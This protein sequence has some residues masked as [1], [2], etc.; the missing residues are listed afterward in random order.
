[1]M[2]ARR[3]PDKNQDN[4]EK[5]EECF[6]KASQTAQNMPHASHRRQH[7]TTDNKERL[8]SA[9]RTRANTH[10]RCPGAKR[11]TYNIHACTTRTQ[12]AR[13][14][15]ATQVSEAYDVLHNPEKRK[16]YDQFG[17]QGLGGG[18]GCG[19]GG[20]SGFTSAQA[21]DIFKAFF[22]GGRGMPGMSFSFGPCD[23]KYMR[24][25][26]C[27]CVFYVSVVCHARAL[28]TRQVAE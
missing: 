18:G 28:H 6:K 22:G 19:G 10:Q 11:R 3:H 15:H 8:S 16:T 7:T 13:W 2:T 25:V 26:C 21:E 14:R 1:M 27:P 5:A 20:P 17:K 4:K 12:T 9:S 23:S 24:K